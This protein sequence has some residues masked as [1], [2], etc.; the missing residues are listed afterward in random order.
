MNCR[1]VR[2]MRSLMQSMVQLGH[3]IE[4]NELMQMFDA[5]P[6]EVML[7]VRNLLRLSPERSY[8][9]DIVE[10]EALVARYRIQ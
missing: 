8:V 5:T 3:Q 4:L 10:G 7:S 1:K 2:Y 9:L 6:D